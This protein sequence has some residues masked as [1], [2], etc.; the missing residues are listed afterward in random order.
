MRRASILLL[1]ALT[2]FIVFA[3]ARELP[4]VARL[5]TTVLVA[6]LPPI[7][8]LQARLLDQV[9]LPSRLVLY[10]Q[11]ALSLWLLAGATAMVAHVSGIGTAALG[12]RALS[13]PL[14]L[15]W[16]GG[17]TVGGVLLMLVAHRLGLRESSTLAGLLPQSGRERLAFL[18]LSITAGICEE[19]VFRGFLIPAIGSAIGALGLA[20]VIAAAVFGLVHAYQGFGG[21]VRAALL[22]AMLSLPLLVAGSILPAVLAHAAIDVIG[23]YWLGPRLID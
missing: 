9:E 2:A 1:V 17:L 18:G 8:I 22:G 5:W 10:G 15:V 12:L 3:G 23:G 4:P 14:L 11:S 16:T 20:A 13:M 7:S 19:L 21:A 6:V